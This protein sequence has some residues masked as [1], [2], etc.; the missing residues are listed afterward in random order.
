VTEHEPYAPGVVDHEPLLQVDER[1][2]DE[3]AVGDVTEDEVYEVQVP[4]CAVTPQAPD[5]AHE[6]GDPAAHDAFAYGVTDQE[7]LEQ[8]EVVAL[9][10]AVG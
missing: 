5:A 2:T 4:L 1:A 8:V 9:G 3:H 10:H 7:P 6:A